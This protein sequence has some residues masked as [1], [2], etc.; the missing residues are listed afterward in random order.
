[1]EISIDIDPEFTPLVYQAGGGHVEAF[2]KAMQ[3]AGYDVAAYE[4]NMALAAALLEPQSRERFEAKQ[5][6]FTRLV[7]EE[8]PPEFM[9]DV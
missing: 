4:L 3:D 5:P 8:V 9:D 6:P 1:M 7:G 2:S